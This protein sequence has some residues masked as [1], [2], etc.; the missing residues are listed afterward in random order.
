[1][2][3]QEQILRL[4]SIIDQYLQM[5]RGIY[6]VAERLGEPPPQLWIDNIRVIVHGLSSKIN[7]LIDVVL[8]EF[9]V[10]CAPAA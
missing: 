10:E 6:E 5:M 9:V 2:D 4:Q 1:M 3:E 8:G 7:E